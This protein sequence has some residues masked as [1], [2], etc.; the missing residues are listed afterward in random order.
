MINVT[1]SYLPDLDEYVTYLKGI[2]ERVHLT[3]DGPLVRE[4]EAELRAYLGVKHLKFCT[5]GTI[6]LQ[7]AIKVLGLSKEV[8]TTPFSYVATTNALLW[9]GCTP[10]FA[11]IRP[12]D[13]NID[14]DKIEALITENTEAIMATHVY[15]NPCR[16]EQIQAIAQKHNLNVIYDAAHTF[17][18]TYNGNSILSYGDVSTCSFHATKVFHTVEGGCIVTNDDAIAEQL[19][20]YRS[21]GHQND[22]YFG[23]GI[24]AKNSEMHA[25]MGLCVL[26]KVD[27]LIAA[28]KERFGYYDSRLDFSRI[29]RPTLTPGTKYNYA[30]YP[31]VLD[32]EETLLR[33]M[34]TLKAQQIFPRRYFYPSLNTLPFALRRG[35]AQ[36]CLV[37]EDIALRVLALPLYPDLP[38]ADV[39]RIAT[40]V[41]EAVMALTETV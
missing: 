14:A 9:E 28:R 22:T 19:H 40:L 11:D 20:H 32:S 5:N 17:G 23:L 41:N 1:K 30:Y 13:Y 36:S 2:W 3:N 21:F 27:D 16:V 37:S 12:D 10:I 29:T 38:E 8:I 33:V 4:L 35:E 6:V 25:A 31:I 24:N 7:L 18:A 39:D 15:G 26:P 34:D